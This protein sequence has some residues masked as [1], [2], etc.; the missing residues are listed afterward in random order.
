MKI[1]LMNTIAPRILKLCIFCSMLWVL[2]SPHVMWMYLLCLFIVPIITA[3][4]KSII[5]VRKER[6]EEFERLFQH[7]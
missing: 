7:Q 5:Q 3:I 2:F 1:L 6:D 4:P